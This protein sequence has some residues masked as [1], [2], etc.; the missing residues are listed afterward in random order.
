VS[1]TTARSTSPSGRTGTLFDLG[2]VQ[3]SAAALVLDP[4]HQPDP[5]VL[6]LG[7][8]DEFLDLLCG[9][10]AYQ[11]QAVLVAATFLLSR[12]WSSIDELAAEV[13]ER[14]TSQAL[15]DYYGYDLDHLVRQTTFPGRLAGTLDLATATGKSYVMYGV[16]RIA[17]NEGR[18]RR[19]LLLCPSLEIEQGLRDKFA[20]LATRDELTDAL[21]HVDGGVRQPALLDGNST[22]EDGSLCIENVHAVYENTGSSLRTAFVDQTGR[23]TLVINDETHHVHTRLKKNGEPVDEATEWWSYCNDARFAFGGILGVTG[24]AYRPGETPYFSDVLYRYSLHRAMQQRFTKEVEYVERQVGGTLDTDEGHQFEQLWTSHE[25]AKRRYGPYDVKPLAIVVCATTKAA[26][27]VAQKFIAWA[28]RVKQADVADKTI[29]VHSRNDDGRA[30]LRTV[31]LRADPTEF[32]VSVSMLTEGWDV[33]N[34]FTIVPHSDRAFNSRLLIAQVLGRGLRVPVIDLA[35]RSAP[36]W[37]CRVLNHSSWAE[38]V[39]DLVADVLERSQRLRLTDISGSDGA[40]EH[41][42]LDLIVETRTVTTETE[43]AAGQDIDLDALYD[44]AVPLLSQQAATTRLQLRNASTQARTQLLVDPEGE[45]LAPV[46]EVAGRLYGALLSAHA[47]DPGTVALLSD[48]EIGDVAGLVE[49]SLRT[50]KLPVDGGVSRENEA[51]LREHLLDRAFP[52]QGQLFSERRKVTT[53]RDVRII[54]TQR[55]RDQLATWSLSDLARGHSHLTTSR[56]ALTAGHEETA[57]LVAAAAEPAGLLDGRVTFVSE[58]WTFKTPFNLTITSFTPERLFL[59]ELTDRTVA[60]LLHAWIKSPDQGFYGI[61]YTMDSG[62]NDGEPRQ[63]NPD[64]LLEAARQDDRR[65][66]VFIV[67]TKADSESSDETRCKI[68]AAEAAVEE[69]NRRLADQRDRP[70]YSFHL[71]TPHDYPSFFHALQ[72]NVETAA[73]YVGKVHRTLTAEHQRLHQHGDQAD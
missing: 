8:Y 70:T 37:R 26:D 10:R 1:T 64:W 66:H 33:A 49:R 61:T 23:D 60:R 15:Q 47:N 27:E 69:L 17:L 7:A 11:K 50:S 56:T 67:E 29:V 43:V 25:D 45:V 32:I 9:D 3:T 39:S 13:W 30:R 31:D 42:D 41:F 40:T 14:P 54:T 58:P 20:Q 62:P 22:V 35:G 63:F 2:V 53:S 65:R 59:D 28:K 57:T 72:R 68:A 73:A 51:R 52:A 38:N 24:T 18:F 21:P 44:A 4:D 48:V 36:T 5:G 71:L 16:A 34:V 55:N 6:D 12:R 46:R 19:V